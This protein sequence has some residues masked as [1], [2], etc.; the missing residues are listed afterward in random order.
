MSM[1]TDKY[2]G[3]YNLAQSLGCEGLEAKEE[4]GKMIINATC[5]TKLDANEIWDKVKEIDPNLSH[6]DLALNLSVKRNDIAGEYEVKSGDTLSAIAKKVTGGKL[7]YQKIFEANRDILSDP[8]K[9][10][11]GQKL[12]IPNF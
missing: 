8:D 10:K 5:P 9:I 12:K 4:N 6:G 11:P 2:G 1:L 7:T 3:V